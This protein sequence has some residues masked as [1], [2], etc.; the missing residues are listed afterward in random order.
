MQDL[1]VG[2]GYD[3]HRF[4]QERPLFLGGVFI[5]ESPGLLG[6]SDADV[7]IHS[8][9]DAF[10]GACGKR[11]IGQLFPPSDDTYKNADSKVLLKT[12]WALV[13]ELGWKL[14]NA[15]IMVIAEAPRLSPYIDQMIEVLSGIL[16]CE[17]EQISIKATTN[18]G[19]GTIGRGEGIA[20]QSVVLLTR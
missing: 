14:S 10:L 11:D 17:R 13:S 16:L 7:I 6:H 19:L 15:D 20:S 2:L 1:R 12:V 3:I 18:E 9:M 8:L 5:P 4:S